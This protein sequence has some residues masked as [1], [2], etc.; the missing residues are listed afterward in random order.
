MKRST[1]SSNTTWRNILL[2]AAL[3][4]IVIIVLDPNNSRSPTAPPV[5]VAVP[6]SATRDAS[7]ETAIPQVTATATAR[8]AASPTLTDV[9]VTAAPTQPLATNRP[10]PTET[11]SVQ[12][13][14]MPAQLYDV[15][16]T[17]NALRC[18]DTRCKLIE[19]YKRRNIV[20]VVGMVNGTSYKGD[21]SKVWMQ[22]IS[23]DGS[24]IYMHS[25]FLTPHRN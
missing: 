14:P 5:T 17:A 13:T 20:V 3:V 11:S 9:P 18:P 10:R 6:P 21:K 2:L 7:V 1:Q 23:H 16:G 24:R 22:I 15:T 25:S 19:T 4:I 12:V 8:V